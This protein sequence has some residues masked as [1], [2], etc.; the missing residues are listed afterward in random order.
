[1]EEEVVEPI[2]QTAKSVAGNTG[3]HKFPCP[4][5]RFDFDLIFPQLRRMGPRRLYLE[6]ARTTSR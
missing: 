2:D 5:K 6:V 4:K 3:G 1:M